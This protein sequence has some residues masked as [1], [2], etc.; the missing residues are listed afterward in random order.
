MPADYVSACGAACTQCTASGSF[1]RPI[2]SAG[3]CGTACI[4]SCNAACVD[5]QRDPTNC[6][7]CGTTCTGGQACTAGECRA[8]CTTGP[9]FAGALPYLN[10]TTSTGYT[11]YKF[12][13]EDL[14]A[15]G[16]ADLVDNGNTGVQIRYANADGT[17]GAPVAFA[18][19]SRPINF[20]LGD[21]N[22][23][24]RKDIVS[25]RASTSTSISVLLNSGT[26]FAA[27]VSY[28]L[29][30]TPTGALAIGDINADGRPDI[31]AGSAA[32]T[33]YLL[34]TTTPGAFA[35][36]AGGTS[37]GVSSPTFADV[38]DFNKDGRADFLFASGSQYRVLLSSATAGTFTLQPTSAAASLSIV[39]GQAIDLNADTNP[40]LF[41]RSGAGGYQVLGNGDGTFGTGS[42]ITFPGSGPILAADVNGDALVD[43]L[44]GSTSLI[45][46]ALAT[47]PGAW[48]ATPPSYLV[49]SPGGS[50]SIVAV[51]QLAG[52]A[53]PEIFST[54]VQSGAANLSLLINNGAGVFSGAK[55]SGTSAA[56]VAVSGDVDGD[57]DRDLVLAPTIGTNGTGTGFVTLGSND[58]NF[59][60][61]TGSIPLRGDELALGKL[62]QDAFE[63]LVALVESSTTPGVDLFLGAM[64]GTFGAP[65][66]LSASALPTRV[67]ITNLNGDSF[68][69]ILIGTSSTVE[70]FQGNGDGTFGARQVIVTGLSTV[71]ALA[72]ADLNLDTRADVLVATGTQLRVYP[73]QGGGGV[74]NAAL[75]TVTIGTTNLDL[76]VG[77]FDQDGRPDV[78]VG[79]TAGALLFRGTGS[80]ALT[81]QA[82][83]SSLIGRLR[84]VDLDNDGFVDLVASNADVQVARGQA[85]FTFAPRQVFAPGRV[86][87]TQALIIDRFNGDTFR[88][89]AVLYPSGEIWAYLGVCR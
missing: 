1:D 40:D 66:T 76:G 26:S 87:S 89:V 42:A 28:T 70:W 17:F 31:V 19:T 79:T 81:A 44:G 32:N 59:G 58:G 83:Q 84:V 16:R 21:V 88:D 4:T 29:S 85:N 46:V 63:D 77:D 10:V 12:L 41:F 20:V 9:A 23:D 35:A 55:V 53:R 75:T 36:A 33:Y 27:P 80:G 5:V 37:H 3:S 78:A 49:N 6:G 13:A 61:P 24:G 18:L 30:A 34:Q 51:A 45:Y 39:S 22:A 38:A 72:V 60:A 50:Q 62:N 67:L 57:L 56:A 82:S 43:L 69:D 54:G 7:A 68:N 86:L 52:D 71:S 65:T 48:P 2:C 11:G 14:N 8:T 73:G 64:G 74:S 25:V 47:G 15:D